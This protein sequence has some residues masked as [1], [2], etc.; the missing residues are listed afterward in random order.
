MPKT[1]ILVDNLCTWAR[2]CIRRTK[3]GLLYILRICYTHLLLLSLV[4]LYKYIIIYYISLF[5]TSFYASFSFILFPESACSRRT[6]KEGK[7]RS[8]RLDNGSA[9]DLAAFS[10]TEGFPYVLDEDTARL[11]CSGIPPAAPCM[12]TYG[13]YDENGMLAAVMTA[14]FCLVFPHNDSPHGRIVHISGAFTRED[15]RKRHYASTLLSAIENDAYKYFHADYLCCDSTADRLYVSHGF[16]RTCGETR[17]W[18]PL[19]T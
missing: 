16:I 15:R 3:P 4:L 11:Y 6:Y 1:G 2:F 9:A 5:N 7:M 10:K 17:L 14:T 8:V 12:Q 13:I 18:K 19:Y